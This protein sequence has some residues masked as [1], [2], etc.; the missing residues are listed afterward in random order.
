MLMVGTC[1]RGWGEMRESGSFIL[2]K[3]LGRGLGMELN[4]YDFVL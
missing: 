1:R 2:E 3:F 4:Y